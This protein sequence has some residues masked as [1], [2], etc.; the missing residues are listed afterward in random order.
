[1]QAVSSDEVGQNRKPHGKRAER[2]TES[3]G[4]DLQFSDA[5]PLARDA[6]EF[7]VHLLRTQ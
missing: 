1:M 3:F 6:Q 4:L 7:N 2:L 5:Y